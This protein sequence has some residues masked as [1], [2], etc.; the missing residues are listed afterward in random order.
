MSKSPVSISAALKT[1]R[2]IHP[3]LPHPPRKL[4]RWASTSQPN[5]TPL[6]MQICHPGRQSPAGAGDRGFLSK[7][8]APSAI[9]LNIG[10]NLFARAVQT[11][12]FG[13]PKEMSVENIQETVKQFA[14]TAK[15][16]YETGF[17]GVELHGAHG[18]LLAQFLFPLS[19]LR[20]DAYDGTAAKR[21][22]IVID[23]IRAIRAG[24]PK[25][26]TVG[27]KLNSA[28]VGRSENLDE[29][30][31]QI[32]LILKEKVDFLEISGGTYETQE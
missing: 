29:T 11:L 32:D 21:A 7:A 16:A 15:L 27:I 19:N 5:G 17:S 30:L 14:A 12:M 24:V 2:P 10:D 26:F 28:D 18:Y 20:T 13:T 22:Q 8:L 23:V 6:I 25:T 31:E 1:S 9:P 3:P 4:S